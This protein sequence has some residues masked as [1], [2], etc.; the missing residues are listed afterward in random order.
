MIIVALKGGTGNQLFQYAFGRA[1]AIKNHDTLKL[2]LTTLKNAEAVGNIHRAYNLGAFNIAATTA[3]TEDITSLKPTPSFVSI[4]LR[5][6][7]NRVWGDTTVRYNP[8]LLEK[9]GDMYLDGYWQSPLYFNAIRTELLRELTLQSP[10]SAA[11]ENYAT[12]IKSTNAVAL[13]VRR[14]DYIKNPNVER[15]FGTCTLTYYKAAMAEIEKTLP[16][17][18]YFIFSDDLPW[19]QENLPVGDTAVFV[20]GDGMSDVEDLMLMS[21]CEHNI[22][23]NSSF[24][25]WG[26]WLNQNPNKLVIA[27]TPWFDRSPYD[28]ELL[29]ANWIQVPK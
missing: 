7:Q 14:G 29:P 8:A 28:K 9:T 10:M 27:P 6:L 15:Q 23:A 11:A 24:S 16:N 12:Q 25:W 2:D 4:L 13:H 21:L 17:P 3:S 19:V 26:A 5:K 1:L 22:I 20:T 18:T